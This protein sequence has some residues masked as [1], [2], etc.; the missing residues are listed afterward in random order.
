MKRSDRRCAVSMAAMR[1]VAWITL[2][3]GL[4]VFAARLPIGLLIWYA[5]RLTSQAVRN[6]V[7]ANNLSVATMTAELV[8]QDLEHS[9]NLA[10]ALAAMPGMLEAVQ[11]RAQDAVRAEEEVRGPWQQRAKSSPRGD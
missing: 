4:L 6:L 1:Q 2:P 8:S 3:W 10:R 5:V 11:L 7:Q 9:I